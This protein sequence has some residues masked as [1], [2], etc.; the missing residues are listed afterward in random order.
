MSFIILETIHRDEG[1]G[2]DNQDI[3]ICKFFCKYMQI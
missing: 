2:R 1:D 3:F